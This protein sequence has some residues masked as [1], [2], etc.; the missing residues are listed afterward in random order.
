M[1]VRVFC[2]KE[3]VEGLFLSSTEPDFLLNTD[4]FGD[5]LKWYRSSTIY[6]AFVEFNSVELDR[7][8]W[9]I[10]VCNDAS[11]CISMML[12]NGCL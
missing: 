9:S 1:A 5:E 12:H 8:Y 10:G 7:L 2:A 11:Y 6:F 3:S 4:R